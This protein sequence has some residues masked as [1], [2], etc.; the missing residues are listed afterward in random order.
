MIQPIIDLITNELALEIPAHIMIESK[1]VIF[2]T[3]S[4]TDN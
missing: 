2:F 3:L 4:Q 1:S